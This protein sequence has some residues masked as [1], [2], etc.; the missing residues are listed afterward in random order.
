MNAAELELHATT[1][2]VDEFFVAGRF[3]DQ[4]HFDALM[5]YLAA[6]GVKRLDWLYGYQ[7]TIY[8]DYPGG[9]DL[10][11]YAV[12]AAHARG[13]RFDVVL[14]PFE[15]AAIY[16]MP[17][18]F[19]AP[20]PDNFWPSVRGHVTALEPFVVQHP[21]W[22]WKHRPSNVDGGGAIRSIRLVSLSDEATSLTAKDLC[23]WTTDRVGGEFQ[24]YEAPFT[25]RDTVQDRSTP[26][27][28]PARRVLVLDGLN[29]PPSQR[30]IEIRCS[31]PDP[32]PEFTG[33]LRQM[34]ELVDETGAVLPVTPAMPS[35]LGEVWKRLTESPIMRELIWYGRQADFRD[36][37]KDRDQ[38]LRAGEHMRH[39]SGN[40]YHWMLHTLKKGAPVT[41]A[42]G[43]DDHVPI[44]NP[45]YP[46]VREH[47]M[48]HVRDCL[49]RGVDGINIRPTTHFIA[50][51][52]GD[53]GFNEPVLEQMAK[54]PDLDVARVN[55][56]A[57]TLLLREIHG[58]VRSYGKAFGMHVT[59][60]FVDPAARDDLPIPN[61]EWQWETWLRELC[62]YVTLHG[63]GPDTPELLDEVGR[64]GSAANLPLTYRPRVGADQSFTVRL[65]D[66][67]YGFAAQHPQISAY[68]LYETANFTRSS[69]P[70][71][72]EGAAFTEMDASGETSSTRNNKQR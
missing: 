54:N 12:K 47:W 58:L 46:E 49:D 52:F 53:Y 63:L 19:P 29:I 60:R 26:G 45:I 67:D 14:K 23:I 30:Y 31:Q 39:Y 37:C 7:W 25:F 57:F 5:D 66:Y 70:G 13:L 40:S 3:L 68:N 56:D 33:E 24:R 32:H 15:A 36:F 59:P 65:A 48:A 4:A 6:L 28:S 51:N 43:V 55:G 35:P 10:L 9:F 22:C 38:V 64:L 18:T 17:Q 62:D 11:A 8:P 34:V 72:F 50:H 16:T 1:D 61:T 21:E 44:L 41:M 42:R 71:Q 20:S 69:A 2:V 27:D